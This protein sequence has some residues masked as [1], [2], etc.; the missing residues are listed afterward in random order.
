MKRISFSVTTL[1]IFV[2]LLMPVSALA[3]SHYKPHVSVGGR[4]G[5]TMSKMSF[6]PS[7]PQGWNN[8]IV[9]GLTARY[10][11]EKVFGLIGEIVFE[12]RGWKES[13]KDENEGL[14]YS[15]T[16]SYLEI[17]LMTH[18]YFG[19]NRFKCF[20]NA[21]PE[22]SYMI[23]DNISSNFDYNNPASVGIP[24]MRH[25]NQMSME[26]K[27]KFDYGI[28]AGLGFEFYVKPRHSISLEGRFYYGLGNIFSSAKADEFSA[29]RSMSL[30]VT[31]GYNFRLK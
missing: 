17:P 3:W 21:G 26:I 25:V 30:Q 13:F 14:Q 12:Q 7:V 8:G 31:L 24:S 4:A 15:R 23:G 20:F 11:E 22:F 2:S 29:S 1:I 27:N 6:S 28:T 5:M 9:M 10:S 19:S 18:I 16:L